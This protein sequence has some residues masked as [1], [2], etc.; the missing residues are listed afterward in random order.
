MTVSLEALAMSGTSYVDCAIDV[1]E[2]ERVDFEQNPPPH[3]LVEEEEDNYDQGYFTRNYK[4]G[5]P[6][7]VPT[8]SSMRDHVE[9]DGSE[10]HCLTFTSHPKVGFCKAK[11]RNKRTPKGFRLLGSMMRATVTLS[12]IMIEY[13]KKLSLQQYQQ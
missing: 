4:N 1:E 10:D 8:M 7:L 12:M 9:E 2:W 5:L 6:S 11:S 13:G 3:L